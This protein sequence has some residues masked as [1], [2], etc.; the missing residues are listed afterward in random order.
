MGAI[1]WSETAGAER[2]RPR[3]VGINHVAIEVGDIDQALAFYGKIF[4]PACV[5]SGL[6]TPLSS[7]AISSSI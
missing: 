1:R 4:D 5:R 7:S 6:A 3:P 2:G